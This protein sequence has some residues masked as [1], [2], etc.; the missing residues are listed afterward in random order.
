[1]GVKDARR[2]WSREPGIRGLECQQSTLAVM[3]CSRERFIDCQRC[4]AGTPAEWPAPLSLVSARGPCHCAYFPIPEH[5]CLRGGSKSKQN[6]YLIGSFK[7]H[8][9]P[10]K[11][12]RWGLASVAGG[13]WG[14]HPVLCSRPSGLLEGIGLSFSPCFKNRPRRLASHCA[15]DSYHLQQID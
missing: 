13:Y 8:P 4:D 14:S 12:G 1:M 6:L 15:L 3:G 5:S 11:G 9:T 2:S 7:V 10:C